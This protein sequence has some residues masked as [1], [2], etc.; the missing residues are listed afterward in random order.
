MRASERRLASMLLSESS[1]AAKKNN[2][3]FWNA[4][5]FLSIVEK[6]T[7]NSVSKNI[8]TL[9]SQR[10]EYVMLSHVTIMYILW[11]L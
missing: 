10:T 5:Y 6:Q 3:T 11:Q 2:K 9:T 8:Q 4:R 1:V 7:L